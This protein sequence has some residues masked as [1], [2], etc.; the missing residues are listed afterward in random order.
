[1]AISIRPSGVQATVEGRET[2]HHSGRSERFLWL[3]A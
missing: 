3:G 1:M 2:Y